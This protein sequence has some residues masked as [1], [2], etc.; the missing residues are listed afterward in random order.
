M[1]N[2]QLDEILLLFRKCSSAEIYDTSNFTDSLTTAKQ[3]IKDLIRKEV[4][5]ANV[6]GFKSGAETTQKVIWDKI[7]E[8]ETR[9]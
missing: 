2:E 3:S 1:I 4:T 7:A 9:S 6:E 5:K 8:N